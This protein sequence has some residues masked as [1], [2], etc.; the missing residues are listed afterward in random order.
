MCAIIGRAALGE[1]RIGVPLAMTWE[2]NS[3]EQD[4]GGAPGPD[5]QSFQSHPILVYMVDDAIRIRT[6]EHG[7]ASL[8][9][10]WLPTLSVPLDGR[11]SE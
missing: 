5:F 8:S 3:H 6:D 9:S 7:E 10:D 1:P 11:A 2:E 4:S